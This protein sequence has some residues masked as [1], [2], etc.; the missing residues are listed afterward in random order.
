[1]PLCR[2][3][4]AAVSTVAR[5][6]HSSPR[7]DALGLGMSTLSS[8]LRPSSTWLLQQPHNRREASGFRRW[9]G[10]YLRTS[11]GAPRLLPAGST[12]RTTLSGM[13][14][15]LKTVVLLPSLNDRRRIRGMAGQ[16]FQC[17][18]ARPRSVVVFDSLRCNLV[19]R[20]ATISRFGVKKWQL[21]VFSFLGLVWCFHGYNWFD[22]IYFIISAVNDLST[23][24]LCELTTARVNKIWNRLIKIAK[25]TRE[26][27]CFQVKP[28]LV[29]PALI[30]FWSTN[31]HR[32]I[33]NK[34][35]AMWN[36]SVCLCL[37][38]SVFFDQFPCESNEMGS[39][40]ALESQEL[41][42][43]FLFLS[44]ASLSPQL[45][46]HLLFFLHTTFLPYQPSHLLFPHNPLQPVP[47]PSKRSNAQT[48]HEY[49]DLK[50]Y[51]RGTKR[52]K[53]SLIWCRKKKN[54]VRWQFSNFIATPYPNCLVA[55]TGRARSS[56][57][58]L[59]LY[60]CSLSFKQP[61]FCQYDNT[62][63]PFT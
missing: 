46:C 32:I 47:F 55:G 24:C 18:P 37:L 45:P 4:P 12:Q 58:N 38:T 48:C 5:Y 53:N 28:K 9:R 1:M 33:P 44:I 39:P 50:S 10:A 16:H 22:N 3:L 36:V 25:Q 23:A 14:R 17:C 31:T 59:H 41:K 2:L 57:H 60:A 34:T 21:I 11:C 56:N 51:S 26:A 20:F 8:P 27:L 62:W 6:V 15:L 49:S 7:G 29:K 43:W 42:S 30:H 40:P 61:S 63:F 35:S 54:S 13:L 19:K 52:K